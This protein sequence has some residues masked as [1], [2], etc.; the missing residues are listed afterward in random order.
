MNGK[1]ANVY[2]MPGLPY[3]EAIEL[4]NIVPIMINFIRGLCSN[5]FDSIVRDPKNRLYSL[6]PFSELSR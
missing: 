2:N 1:A 6:M 3:Q 4:V 5:T